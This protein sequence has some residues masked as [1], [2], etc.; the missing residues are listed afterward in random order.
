MTTLM[1]ITP[2]NRASPGGQFGKQNAMLRLQADSGTP[3]VETRA[4]CSIGGGDSSRGKH[5]LAPSPDFGAG[6]VSCHGAK[7]IK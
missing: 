5:L 1:L 6:K 7:S 2:W 4:M 3:D